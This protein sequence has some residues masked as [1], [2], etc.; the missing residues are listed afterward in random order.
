[1]KS[2]IGFIIP[3]LHQVEKAHKLDTNIDKLCNNTVL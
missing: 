3:R 2:H 1:M